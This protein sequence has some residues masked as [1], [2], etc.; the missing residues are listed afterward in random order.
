VIVSL[1]P[2]KYTALIRGKNNGTGLTSLEAY[3]VP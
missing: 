3:K 2:G 1:S